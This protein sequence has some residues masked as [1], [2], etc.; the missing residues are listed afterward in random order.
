MLKLTDCYKGAKYDGHGIEIISVPHDTDSIGYDVY[1]ESAYR[2]EYAM[3]HNPGKMSSEL[4]TE[5]KSLMSH[6]SSSLYRVEFKRCTSGDC[7]VCKDHVEKDCPLN[8]FFAQFPHR[9]VPEPIPVLP[10]FPSPT[11]DTELYTKNRSVDVNACLENL[12][13]PKNPKHSV[14]PDSTGV[15]RRI[16]GHYRT[17]GDLLESPIP[18]SSSMFSTDFYRGKTK[19]I[20]CS[21]CREPVVLRSDA[22]YSRHCATV[23]R[24]GDDTPATENKD[25]TVPDGLQ[26][27]EHDA[28]S[29]ESDFDDEL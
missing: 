3:I 28:A 20:K 17:F 27:R 24:R 6:M 12:M 25:D 15:F 2:A 18:A 4:R 8:D 7:H 21:K 9:Q 1:P 5:Y 14:D 11:F 23:H 13:L 22:A 19:R 16:A 10:P 29:A 26:V